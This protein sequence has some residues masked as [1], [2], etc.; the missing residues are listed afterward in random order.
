MKTN[1]N[2]PIYLFSRKK[3]RKSTDLGEKKMGTAIGNFFF[4]EKRIFNK[5]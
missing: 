1:Q 2:C 3:K 5:F 4:V